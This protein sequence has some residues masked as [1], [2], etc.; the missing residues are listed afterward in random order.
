MQSVRSHRPGIDVDAA[1]R[2]GVFS[3]ID[4]QR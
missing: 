1:K 3:F 4:H 2:P